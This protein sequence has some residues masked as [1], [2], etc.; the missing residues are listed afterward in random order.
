MR[1]AEDLPF[2]SQLTQQTTDNLGHAATDTDI[3]FVKDKRWYACRLTGDHLNGKT[4]A[5]DLATGRDLGQGPRFAA[6]QSG[7]AELDLL[8]PGSITSVNRQQA[9][10]EAT[11]TEA[12]VAA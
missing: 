3:D 9:D 11:A 8:E 12:P 4:D 2:G 6:R 7:N 10:L 5:R 1:D